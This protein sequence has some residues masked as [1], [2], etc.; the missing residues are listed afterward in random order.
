MRESLLSLTL[1]AMLSLS[2]TGAKASNYKYCLY[3]G[4]Y[5]NDSFL[6]MLAE[7]LA[8]REGIL[9]DTVCTATWKQAYEV[10]QKVVRGNAKSQEDT[11]IW[12]EANA[13]GERA[14]VNS[15]VRVEIKR[16]PG[17]FVSPLL[18]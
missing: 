12:L 4:F 7:R 10:H 9:G 3:A 13:F 1:V 18:H 11:Q 16:R 15:G 2:P 8:A 6:G 14:I 5:G 17:Q